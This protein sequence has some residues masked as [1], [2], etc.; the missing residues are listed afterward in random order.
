M[1]RL[2]PG[3]RILIATSVPSGSSAKC[4][5]ATD[6]D[7][8]GVRSNLRKTSSTG[9]PY[10]ASSTPSAWSDGKG[11]TRSWSRASSLAMSGASRSRRVDSIWPNLTKIELDEDRAE[12]FERP[13]QADRAALVERAPEEY[14][15]PQARQ[16]PASVGVEKHLIESETQTDTENP[17]KTEEAHGGAGR[18]K[19]GLYPEQRADSIPNRLLTKAPCSAIAGRSHGPRGAGAGMRGRVDETWRMSGT[20]AGPGFAHVL[21]AEIIASRVGE[22]RSVIIQPFSNR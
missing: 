10:W 22:V 11:G 12:R 20:P 9:L 15:P 17:G 13:A 16:S 6:A 1:T 4:T 2:M 18:A 3:R 21:P 7:A 14:P 5:C 19:S 8:T